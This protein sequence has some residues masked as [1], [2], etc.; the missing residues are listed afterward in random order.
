MTAPEPRAPRREKYV[1]SVFLGLANHLPRFQ[2]FESK[3]D[4]AAAPG[5]SQH[6]R[7]V[8]DSGPDHDPPDR[9]RAPADDRRR[10]VR[11]HRGAVCSGSH[12][13]RITIGRNAQ[14]GSRVSFE[15]VS[16]GLVYAPGRGRGYT[17]RP[18]CVEDEVWIGA[19]AIVLQGVTIGRGAVITAGAV[20]DDDVPAGAIAGGVPARVIRV[21]DGDPNPDRSPTRQRARRGGPLQTDQWSKSTPVSRRTRSASEAEEVVQPLPDHGV[22]ARSGTETGLWTASLRRIPRADGGPVSP[23]LALPP[24]Q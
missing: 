11:E 10:H 1:E 18:I 6:P 24:L 5:R 21:I 4:P 13:A 9:R 8:H 23:A 12:R 20:V 22:Q 17:A 15:T 19:G 3:R 2:R 16:H 14:V 7:A